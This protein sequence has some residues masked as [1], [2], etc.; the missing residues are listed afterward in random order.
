MAYR[1][2]NSQFAQLVERALSEVPAQFAAALEEVPVEIRERATP[3]QR[4]KVGLGDR[5][6]LLGLYQGAPL[7]HRSV[8]APGISPVIYIFQQDIELASN[9]EADLVRRVRTTVLHEVGHH[10]GLGEEDLRRLGYG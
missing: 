10:F 4:R 7:T 9:S 6:L 1:V 8:E 2:S 3:Q 5:G